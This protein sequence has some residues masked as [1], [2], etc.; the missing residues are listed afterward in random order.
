MSAR[1]R[2][3]PPELVAPEQAAMIAKLEVAAE[4]EAENSAV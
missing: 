3:A 1:Q 4:E 2:P